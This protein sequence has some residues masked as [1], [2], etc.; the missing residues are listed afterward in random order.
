MH[1]DWRGR[2]ASIFRAG[3]DGDSPTPPARTPHHVVWPPAHGAGDGNGEGAY[4]EWGGDLG[5]P[6]LLGRRR[7]GAF[8][9]FTTA[10][11]DYSFT[12]C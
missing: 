11:G 6:G 9:V 2:T 3:G 10:S 4:G 12:A 1:N 8:V 5:V 7:E